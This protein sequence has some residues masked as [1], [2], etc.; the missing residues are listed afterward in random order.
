MHSKKKARKVEAVVLDRDKKYDNNNTFD[1]N[2]GNYISSSC[3]STVS[4]NNSNNESIMTSICSAV[5]V[6]DIFT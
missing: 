4:S 6:Q 1:E 2:R 5:Q 3:F